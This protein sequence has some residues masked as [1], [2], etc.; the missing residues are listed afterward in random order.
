M[1]VSAVVD[2]ASVL[3]SFQDPWSPR[4]VATLNN[5]DIRVVKTTGEFTRHSHP[6]TD[7]LFLVLRG[8]LTIRMDAGDVELGP[9]QLYV[10]PRGVPHQPVS[11]EGAEVMLIEPAATVN[12]GDTPSELTAKRQV[13]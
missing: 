9:G 11:A 5:Y 6:E 13:V 4:T 7:E 8:S 12:T 10:V 3:A 2:L 1:G